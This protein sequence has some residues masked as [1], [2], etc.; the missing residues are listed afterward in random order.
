MSKFQLAA[1]AQSVL[2]R[3]SIISIIL[4]S[5]VS[6]FIFQS[7]LSNYQ[8][9]FSGKKKAVP[10][11]FNLQTTSGVPYPFVFVSRKPRTMGSVY[12]NVPL[13]MPGV[14]SHSRTRTSAP[15]KLQVCDT[16]GVITTLID[17]SNPTSN[18]FNL[19]DVNAPN[20]SYDGT[21]V[22][23]SG[24]PQAPTGQP[25]DTIPN[26]DLGAWRIYTININGT[27]LTQ[28]TFTDLT[29]NY[30]QLN[31]MVAWNKYDDIDPCF[32]PDGRIVFSST[33]FP[34]IAHYSGVRTSN[35]YVMDANGN[36]MHRI[37]SERNGADRPIIDPMTGKIVFA[38]WWRNYRFAKDDTTTIAGAL[39]GGYL[40][41]DGLTMDRSN[42]VGPVGDYLF[43]NAWHAASI[44]PDGTDLKMFTGTYRTDPV[45]HM[46]GGAFTPQ[47]D[48]I[49]NYFPMYNMTEAAALAG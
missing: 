11:P 5:V 25:Y 19:I 29:L 6:V 12:W 39:P 49:T 21:K 24:L 41:K 45:N 30:A 27:G 20:V 22:I 3:P 1:T 10:P 34:T 17:G 16:S 32:L 33:R 31:P 37:T 40:Q 9:S 44:N 8:L 2:L 13:D 46:Y 48:L 47:G 23:F 26:A 35:L 28:L 18:I 15:G 38:R 43:R 4:L 7:L 14:G 42:T 36:N